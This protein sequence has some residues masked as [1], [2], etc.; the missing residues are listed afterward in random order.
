M[1]TVEQQLMTAKEFMELPDPP[2]GSQQELWKGVVI[3]MPPPGGEHGA[4]CLE[5]GRRVANVVAE[6]K[7][8]TVT[9]NDSGFIGETDPDSVFGPDIGFWSK[10]RLPKA[11]KGYIDIPPDLAI[12]VV[13]PSDTHN[14]LQR[15]TMEYLKCG[16]KLI[17]VVNPELRTVTVYRSLDQLRILDEHQTLSGEEI[18]PG[19]SCKVSELFP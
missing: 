9:S 10:E 19:F 13:S 12:E 2:D 18:L 3:T 17:W 4:C 8:G 11:P 7:L 15:K 16:V 5:I 14:R 1:A 6:K